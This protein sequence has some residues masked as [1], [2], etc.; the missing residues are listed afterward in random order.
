M[1]L[2]QTAPTVTVG[3]EEQLRADC[4]LSYTWR[5]EPNKPALRDLYEK[6]KREQWNAVAALPWAT[7]VDPESNILPEQNNPLFGTEIWARMNGKEQARFRHHSLA[8]L[9]SNFM[10]GEQGALLATAQIVDTVP[11]IDAKLYA[12]T[13]V[14][15]EA[16]HVEAY[17]R[18]LR[19]KVTLAYPCNVHLKRLLDAVLSDPR[20]DVKYLGMQIVVEGLA[21]AA[22]RFIHDFTSEALLKE[23]LHLIMRDEA[24]HVAFGVLSL[25]EHYQRELNERE[26]RERQEF[27]YEAA[28]L[29]RDRLIGVEVY[30][31]LGLPVEEC[32]EIALR[33][34]AL[35]EFRKFLFMRLVPNVK[36]LSLLDPWLRQKFAEMDVL[37]FEDF[38][39]DA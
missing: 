33:S 26:L 32:R 6:A 21:L 37:K 38:P 13:Q 39:A 11:F 27:V 29:M 28:L 24:R 8:W 18:Y 31:R 2:P 9:L 3:D 34:M 23:M 25:R 12:A 17:E 36:R 19:E 15:D 1:A 22:F 5:Y 10:H 20:W 30:D 7:S 14:M 16:R 35:R 4:P